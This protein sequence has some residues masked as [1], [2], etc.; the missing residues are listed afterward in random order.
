MKP[1]GAGV[2]SLQER[3]AEIRCKC[4]VPP[5]GRVATCRDISGY[6]WCLESRGQG[7]CWRAGMCTSVP[8]QHGHRP[9]VRSPGEE[10]GLKPRQ[11]SEG[12]AWGKAAF[13][14]VGM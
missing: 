12:G 4:N 5:R 13:S 1:G 11:G 10:E 6:Y 7:Y 14:S 9:W 3:R 8:A 2:G